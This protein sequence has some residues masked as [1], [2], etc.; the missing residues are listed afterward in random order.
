MVKYYLLGISKIILIVMACLSLLIGLFFVLLACDPDADYYK[1]A[2]WDCYDDSERFLSHYK[3][4]YE[5]KIEELKQKYSINCNVKLM[6]ELY[7]D[8]GISLKYYLYDEEFTM[9]TRI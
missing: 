5:N 9:I 4:L 2:N 1:G 7:G 6:Q 8:N 3:P